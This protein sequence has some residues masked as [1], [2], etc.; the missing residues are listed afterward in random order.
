[1]EYPRP[2]E[3]YIDNLLFF[4]RYGLEAVERCRR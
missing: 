1:M 2:T 3:Q 4:L